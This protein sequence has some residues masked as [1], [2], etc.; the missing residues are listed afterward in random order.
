MGGSRPQRPLA[1]NMADWLSRRLTNSCIGGLRPSKTPELL[2]AGV[3]QTVTVAPVTI[4]RAAKTSERPHRG[5]P[6][7][8]RIWAKGSVACRQYISSVCC[9]NRRAAKTA[10]LEKAIQV[11]ERLLFVMTFLVLAWVLFGSTETDE[12]ADPACANSSTAWTMTKAIVRQ[13]LGRPLAVKFPDPS[14]RG[15]LEDIRLSYLG[16]CRHRITAF[17]EAFY[18][19]DHPTRRTFVIELS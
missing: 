16:D 2:P 17:V 15:G 12:P 7:R 14:A 10:I 5:A 9:Y 1:E 13:H 8:A 19:S 18:R 11:I 6:S 3:P 4:V